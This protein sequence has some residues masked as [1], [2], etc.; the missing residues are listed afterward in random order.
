MTSSSFETDYT[1]QFDD[2]FDTDTTAESFRSSLNTSVYMG[3]KYQVTKGGYASATL[4][5]RSSLGR[6]RTA[7]GLGYTQE[8]GRVLAVSTTLSK[9]PQQPIN[10]GG[11]MNLRFGGLNIHVV[12]DH[13]IGILDVTKIQKVNVNVGLNFLIGDPRKV[14]IEE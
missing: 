4:A 3:A 8:V 12:A 13:L 14:K 5:N 2:A 9:T 11:G 1:D 10:V 6:L 7:V